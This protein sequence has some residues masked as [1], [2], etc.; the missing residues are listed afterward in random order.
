MSDRSTTF[1]EV[2]NNAIDGALRDLRTCIPAKVVKWEPSKGRADVQILI[3]N[4]T[5]DEEGKRTVAS[6]PVVPG[7]VVQF[8]GSGDCR[9]T[10]PIFDGSGGKAATIG[11]LFFSFRSLDKWLSG[12]GGEVDPELDHAHALA[13]AIFMPGLMPFGAPWKNIDADVATFG[14]NEDGNGRIL[15]GKGEL[16][17]G[18]DA[19]KGVAREDDPVNLGQCYVTVGSGFVTGVFINGVQLPTG[20]DPTAPDRGTISGASE[21]VKAVD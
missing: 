14:D 19:S 16:K 8:P 10:F 15:A 6:F 17:L 13:D 2:I 12:Q 9:M 18:A 20:S 7:V 5:E 1:G 4:V 3:K 11:T 21:H